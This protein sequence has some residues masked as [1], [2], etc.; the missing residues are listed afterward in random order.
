MND[1]YFKKAVTTGIVIVLIAL[2]FL[3]LKPILLSIIMGI[4]LAVVFAPIYEY[5]LKYVKKPNLNSAIICI[6]LILIILIPLIFLTPIII[7]QSFG[8]YVASQKISFENVISNL[9]PSLSDDFS[10]E[11]GGVLNKFIT[12]S[13]NSF[14]NSFSSLIFNLPNFILQLIIVF[15][16]FFFVLRDMAGFEKYVRSLLPFSKSIE[17]RL[18]KSSKDI[19]FSVIYGQI[20]VGAIQ[21]IIVGVGF[22]IFGVPNFLFL[23]ILAILVGI[24]PIVGTTLIWLPVMIFLF[25]AGNDF[26]AVGV[27]AF[28]IVAAFIDNIV[29]PILVSK[30]ARMHPLLILVGMI[31]GL[32]FFG[33][34][35]FILGPLIIAYALIIL[36]IYRG[37]ELKGIFINP[38]Q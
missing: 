32:F 16:T 1:E 34:L 36:E 22:F 21:G 29:R 20:I 19:T 38:S 25:I 12:N 4:I 23:T 14:V 10:A 33:I 13:A 27:A 28:G 5:T 9:L 31:G 2:T 37:K 35:G 18:F 11:L 6:A 30:R 3:V 15:S 7:E 17:D 24:F 8:I 26:H